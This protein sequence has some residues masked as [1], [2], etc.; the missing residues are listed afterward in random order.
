M[1]LPLP[2]PYLPGEH[3]PD[4]FEEKAQQNFDRIATRFPDLGGISLTIRAGAST[5]TFPGG[6]Q[7]SDTEGV[8]HG[9]PATPV[10]VVGS[11]ESSIV[12][13]EII[14]TPGGTSFTWQVRT[15]DGSTPSAGTNVVLYWIAVG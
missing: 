5:G 3:A 6:S 12:G 4:S 14:G 9:C 2:W 1:T 11:I 8:D 13:H 10:A 7:Y 15:T